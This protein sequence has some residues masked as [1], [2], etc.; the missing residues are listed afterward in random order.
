MERRIAMYLHSDLFFFFSFLLLTLIRL[1]ADVMPKGLDSGLQEGTT[2]KA[3]AAGPKG[4]ITPDVFVVG[5]H[6][7]ATP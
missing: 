7:C 3:F 5:P 2:P 4:R 1:K 6:G